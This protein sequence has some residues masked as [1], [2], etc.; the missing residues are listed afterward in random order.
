MAKS[1]KQTLKR[2]KLQKKIRLGKGQPKHVHTMMCQHTGV[3]FFRDEDLLPGFE[4]PN[5]KLVQ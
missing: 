2:K 1:E 5:P 4:L 3:T